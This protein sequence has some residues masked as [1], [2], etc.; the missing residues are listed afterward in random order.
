[1]DL[2]LVKNLMWKWA[3]VEGFKITHCP[4][5]AKVVTG[6]YKSDGQMHSF[7]VASGLELELTKDLKD[8]VTCKIVDE[9]KY[10]M[11]VLKWS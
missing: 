2:E 10:M 9:E 3:L 4:P 8:I 7:Q 11:F 6:S 5:E 1:M